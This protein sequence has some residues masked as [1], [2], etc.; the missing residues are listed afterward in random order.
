MKG[1]GTKQAPGFAIDPLVAE[2]AVEARRQGPPDALQKRLEADFRRL[3]GKIY[4]ETTEANREEA[5]ENLYRSLFARLGFEESLRRTAREFP[6]LTGHLDEI[7]VVAARGDRDE[8]SDLSSRRG[9]GAPRR[10][11]L[12]VRPARL[13]DPPR[14]APFLRFSWLQLADLCDPDFGF[15]GEEPA[16]ELHPT[17]HKALLDAYSLLW[18]V[19]AGARLRVRGFAAP[20]EDLGR[21]ERL[22]QIHSRLSQGALRDQVAGVLDGAMA[23]HGELLALAEKL[24]E[25][26]R[27]EGGIARICTLCRFPS[28]RTLAREEIPPG[29]G[30]DGLLQD[31]PDLEGAVCSHCLER[32][33][34]VA[35]EGSPLQAAS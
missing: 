8:G 22:S 13:A 1:L 15:T 31:Y 35:M 14:A 32:Y 6:A 19:S 12:R 24:R 10:A 28:Q 20:A 33:E 17:E 21:R 2:G 5:F 11:V 34:L 3:A 18:G 26:L 23:R 9:A 7:V 4:S 16:G 25:H 27:M 30:R 29:P